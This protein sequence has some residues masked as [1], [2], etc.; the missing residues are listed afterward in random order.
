MKGA[1][2]PLTEPSEPEL[3]QAAY[4]VTEQLYERLTETWNNGQRKASREER[5]Q[6]RLDMHEF[7]FVHQALAEEYGTEYYVYDVVA[8]FNCFR[9]N[10]QWFNIFMKCITALRAPSYN[11]SATY[12]RMWEALAT[13]Q[14]AQWI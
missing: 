1:Y 3:V 5:K 6:A 7:R 2:E 14:D 8:C 10:N 12:L 11:K 9:N 4:E 13:N